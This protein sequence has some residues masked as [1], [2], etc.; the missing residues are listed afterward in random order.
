MPH[1]ICTQL[2][3]LPR[4]GS[5][6]VTSFLGNILGPSVCALSSAA[7]QYTFFQLI[8]LSLSLHRYKFTCMLVHSVHR[9]TEQGEAK[10]SIPRAPAHFSSQVSIHPI[11]ANLASPLHERLRHSV[12]V[13]LFNPPYVPTLHE[14]VQGAQSVG[15]IQGSWAGGPQG[16]SVTD[17]F[18]EHVEVCRADRYRSSVSS[19]IRQTLMS[20]NAI[21]YLVA[22]AENDISSIRDRM[23]QRYRLKS[24]VCL[25]FC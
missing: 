7:V 23:L 17:V 13:I 18:L 11:N 25:S 15:G 14:E 12:D 9:L 3:S 1:Q 2:T 21:F 24:D 6:C 10:S 8:C 20:P 16:M 22:I 19:S 5:G 4:S